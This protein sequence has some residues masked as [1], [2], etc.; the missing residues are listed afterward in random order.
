[1]SRSRSETFKYGWHVRVLNYHSA[2]RLPE[3][4]TCAVIFMLYCS[5]L[6]STQSL[7][8]LW[9]SYGAD[10]LHLRAGHCAPTEKSLYLLGCHYQSWDGCPCQVLMICILCVSFQSTGRLDAVCEAYSLG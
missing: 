4:P 8:S 7:R 1:M 6:A 2:L 9:R 10:V 5:T 3:P